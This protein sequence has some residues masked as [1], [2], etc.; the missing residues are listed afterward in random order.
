[1]E[2]GRDGGREGWT[3]GGRDGGRE[4]GEGREG[5]RD[6]GR[7]GPIIMGNTCI[8]PCNINIYCMTDTSLPFCVPLV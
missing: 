8:H 3:D 2:G 5:W 4:R 7:E 1:M 6:G